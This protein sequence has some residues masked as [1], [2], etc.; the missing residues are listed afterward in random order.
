MRGE[1]GNLRQFWQELKRRKVVRVVIIY[2]GSAF[3][4]LE[5]VDIVSPSLGLPTWTLN[6]IIVLLC[7]GFFITVILSWVYDITPKGIIKTKPIQPAQGQKEDYPQIDKISRFKNSIAV[8]PFQDMSPQKD[9][10]YFCEGIA[11]D[12]INALSKVGD[13]RV[14]SRMA[15]FQISAT[16][17]DPHEI[18]ERLEVET[19]LSGSVRKAGNRVRISAELV[20]ARNGRQLWSERYDR[21]LEDVFEV[22]DEISENIVK[23]LQVTLSP[24][25]KKAIQRQAPV[26]IQAYEF[27]LR[28]RRLFHRSG[29]KSLERA[30]QMMEKAIQIDPGFAAAHAGLADTSSMI[31][32]YID[33]S[34][35]NLNRAEEASRKALELAPESA[36]ANAS[37]GLALSLQERYEESE[38]AF[39][40]AIEYDP[41]LFE[42]HYFFARSYWQQGNLEEAVRHFEQ[43]ME[44]RPEDYQTPSLLTSVHEKL[45]NTERAMELHRRTV[46]LTERHL[47]LYPN[48]ARALYLGSGGLIATGETERGLEWAARAVDADPDDP[49]ILYNVAC[50]YSMAG[51]LDEAVD[52]L[53][54]SVAAGFAS[55]DW[56]IN[57]GDFEPIREHPRYRAL[58]NSME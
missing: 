7:V 23:A 36:E 39:Q 2:G 41:K 47:E 31:C 52:S 54:R 3:V 30:L 46:E 18:G 50:T 56:I 4:I 1:P 26:N 32:L 9:Q 40:A 15:A 51:R 17:T 28:G 45:G 58:I 10:D 49:A 33:N 29:R 44:V 38:L 53:E 16:T 21:E 13:L 42:A 5:L 37:R 48:D 12:I 43:A 19:V 20:D 24:K 6:F 55:R 11:E 35:A 25:E 14:S 34:E 22:Q 57:D 8:L 27:Y